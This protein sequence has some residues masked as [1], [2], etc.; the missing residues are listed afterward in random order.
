MDVANSSEAIAAARTARPDLIVLDIDLRELDALETCR[1]IRQQS[2]V[3]MVVL[4]ENGGAQEIVDVLET[5]ADD[6]MTKPVRTEELVARMRNA[7]RHSVLPEAEPNVV[8]RD[9]EID[10]ERRT[11]I[12]RGKR[13]HLTPKEFD[14]LRYLVAHRGRTLSHRDLMEAVW[15]LGRHRDRQPLRVLINELRKK[16]EP[17][18]AHPQYVVT[19]AWFGYRFDVPPSDSCPAPGTANESRREGAS[20]KRGWAPARRARA[21]CPE[22]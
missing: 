4:L 20:L 9:L 16:L 22:R 7:L 12:I 2:G 5:G 15:G 10:F 14:L 11:V 8:T 19:D 21:S 3:R 13:V 6:C 1:E 18:P 17:A